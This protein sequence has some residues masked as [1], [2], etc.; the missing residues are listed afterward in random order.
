MRGRA[1][2]VGRVGALAFA[3]GVGSVLA[4]ATASA[5]DSASASS[6]ESVSSTSHS[7]RRV[8]VG[9]GAKRAATAA[10]IGKPQAAVPPPPAPSPGVIY[11]S[12]DGS[13]NNLTKTSLNATGTNFR[14]LGAAHF[15]DGVS[16]LRT[17]LPNTRTVSNLVVAGNAETPNAEGLSG[18]MY[19]WGQFIDHDINLTLSDDVTHI[20]ITV[21]S[22]DP[23][24]SG[25]I[26][27]TRAV[28]D[29]TTGVAGK[30][31]VTTNN[32][33]GWID[34]SMVYGSDA[35]TAASLRNSAG[36][37][38]TS[39]GNNLPIVDG[40][41][42]AGDIRV[43][44]NPD[45]IALQ[46]LF[47][48]EHNRQVDLLAAAHPDWTGDQL[49]DQAR[50]I[51]TAEIARIT[52]NEFLPHLLGANAIKP[53]RGY[54]PNVDASLTEEFAGAAFRLGHSIVSANLERTDEFGNVVGTPVTLKDAFFQDPE[55]YLADGGGDGLLRH[56]TNDLSNSLDVHIVDD[57][58]NFL[59]GPSAGMDLA[60]INLQRGRDL[61]LGTLNET[62]VALGLK[63]YTS[64]SQIT[65]DATTAAALEA[66]YGDINKVELWI[67]GLAENHLPGAMVGQTFDVIVARQFQA[68]RDGDRFWYQ[69]QGFD[70]ATMREI[71]AT[72][73]SSLILKNTDT[74]NMQADA[75]VFYE[76]RSG[77]SV[78]EN[79][80]SPQLVIG[81]DGGDTLV[82]GTKS[83]ML[84]AGTGNQT[85]TGAAGGDT[86]VVSSAGVNA[87]I[88]DFKVGQDKLKFE[89]LGTGKPR[90]TSVNGNA[91][92]TVGGSTVTLVGVS[93]AK[94]RQGDAILL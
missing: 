36:R 64:F 39:E 20:D 53:Y 76:R 92:V 54:N 8:A 4:A 14:R 68:L 18:M 75:F 55:S 21:P 40:A 50:A 33:T 35:T 57:L 80:T 86:F 34:G 49:Y 52:Y 13:G 3:L 48:R 23:T 10:S 77:S 42:V 94:F 61:G 93:A 11:R 70:K 78:M 44:E 45:L 24:L 56:L 85:M 25:S 87:V 84:V 2:S 15:S 32:V 91:V 67:G 72:T 47:V 43:A 66:A 59:F 16:A 29:P 89:N 90:V 51:V 71:E 46:T 28:I 30:P 6:T 79:P 37:M 7:A 41:Y 1:I 62:R 82:G 65:S 27:M 83:D 73:L 22:G 81:S 31:A 88:T 17:D 19:A 26:S 60:A 38:L 74:E 5:D 58:R 63:A 9:G 12:I 69:N